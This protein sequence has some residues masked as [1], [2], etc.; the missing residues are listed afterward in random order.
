MAKLLVLILIGYVLF[1]MFKGR[2][3]VKEVPRNV[4][5]EETFRDPVCGTYV[6]RGDAV[7][8]SLEGQKHYFCS[9]SCLEKFR[10][11]VETTEKNSIG[12]KK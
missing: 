11:Q 1:Q 8:G 10:E 4:Q 5:E 2:S 6:A 9:M 12:G 3:S 7:V